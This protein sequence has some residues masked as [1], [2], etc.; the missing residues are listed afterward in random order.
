M[1]EVACAGYRA[2]FRM[3]LAYLRP[4]DFVVAEM[5]RE[6]LPMG[7][8]QTRR[9]AHYTGGRKYDPARRFPDAQSLG[10]AL[11][12]CAC[13]GDWDEEG[14]AMVAGCRPV[15]ADAATV[16]WPVSR[17]IPRSSVERTWRAMRSSAPAGHARRPCL[18][19]TP[20]R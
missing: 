7:F 1:P 18:K 4:G 10:R 15:R 16:S 20:R 9:Y 8:T 3:F 19:T 17:E 14:A 5:A 6:F 12:D 11:S 2:I 13:A